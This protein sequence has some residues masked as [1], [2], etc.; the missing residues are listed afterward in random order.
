MTFAQIFENEGLYHSDSFAKGY[1]FR[2]SKNAV[3]NSLELDFVYYENKNKIFPIVQELKIYDGLFNKDYRKV[4]DFSNREKGDYK[5]SVF[6][7]FEAF[8]Y[9]H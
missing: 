2:I 5:L 7:N 6:T 1:A 3:T 9:R 4:F 8:K